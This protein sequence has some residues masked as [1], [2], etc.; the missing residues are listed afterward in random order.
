MADKTIRN[1]QLEVSSTKMLSSLDSFKWDGRLHDPYGAWVA[2]DKETQ[3]WFQVDF[4]RVMRVRK[5]ATQGHPRYDYWT[6]RYALDYTVNDTLDDDGS[7]NAYEEE[8][9]KR[10]FVGNNDSS[11]VVYQYLT[12]FMYARY[13]RLLPLNWTN[14]M[15][16]RLEVYGCF[17][18]DEKPEVLEVINSTKLHYEYNGTIQCLS[19]GMPLP[20]ITWIRDGYDYEGNENATIVTYALDE[21]HVI[22]EIRFHQLWDD[23][24]Y[25]TCVAKNQ[26]GSDQK[27]FY[28][29]KGTPI[30]EGGKIKCDDEDLK[31]QCPVGEYIQITGAFYGRMHNEKC[32]IYDDHYPTD[33]EYDPDTVLYRMQRQCDKKEHCVI[34]TSEAMFGAVGDNYTLCDGFTKYINM[35]YEC[36]GYDWTEWYNTDTPADGIEDESHYSIYKMSSNLCADPQDVECRQASDG[37][38][39]YAL[40]Q[41]LQRPCSLNNEGGL[42]CNDDDQSS[43]TCKD[44]E[45]RFLCPGEELGIWGHEKALECDDE[46]LAIACQADYSIKIHKAFYGRKEEGL[47]SVGNNYTYSLDCELDQEQVLKMVQKNCDNKQTCRLNVEFATVL[48][49]PCPEQPKYL[50]VRFSCERYRSDFARGKAANM[51]SLSSSAEVVNTTT[52]YILEVDCSEGWCTQSA[53]EYEPWWVVDLQATYDINVVTVYTCDDASSAASKLYVRTAS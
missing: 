14:E 21:H 34:H 3:Q 32:I 49:D 2:S 33:C 44:Y 13:I 41:V 50:D 24:G 45:V 9:E 27:S 20:N 53:D 7:W 28:N 10:I 35:T 29:H 26:H 19:F 4:E 25:Y 46:N 6:S 47:C 48:S 23:R 17:L 11:T 12:H 31:L 40:G 15:S 36:I 38:S 22:S 37:Q 30:N 43:G 1:D 8:G 5:F 39:H 42:L 51:S 52:D 18:E 16:L